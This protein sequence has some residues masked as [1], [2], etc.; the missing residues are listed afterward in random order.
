MGCDKVIEEILFMWESHHYRFITIICWYLGFY[1]KN[2]DIKNLEFFFKKR[3]NIS[4]FT[5]EMN[6]QKFQEI[7]SNK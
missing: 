7:N 4:E 1:Q 2:H 6:F 3:E 5:V